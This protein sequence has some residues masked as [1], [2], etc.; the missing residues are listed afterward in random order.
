VVQGDIDEVRRRF[1]ENHYL[2]RTSRNDA[3]LKILEGTEPV[4]EVWLSDDG[5]VHLVG[6]DGP[7][8]RR[9]VLRAVVRC[10]ADLEHLSQEQVSLEG[11]YRK[12]VGL[13][14]R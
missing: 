5:F 9:E 2:V 10:D 7:A 3:V 14:E 4:Q 6:E 12:T 1:T 13:E 8:L 11:I